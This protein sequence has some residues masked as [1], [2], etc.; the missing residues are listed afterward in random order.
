M[1][2]QE[3]DALDAFDVV[4]DGQQFGEVRAVGHVHPVA[5]DDLAQQGHFPDPLARQGAHLAR[6]L[7]DAPALLRASPERDDAER[8]GVRAAINDRHV[9]ADQVSLLVQGQ[10]QVAVLQSVTGFELLGL[11]GDQ[12]LLKPSLFKKRDHGG[13][14]AWSHEDVDEREAPPQGQGVAHADQAAHQADHLI[15]VLLLQDLE[16]SQPPVNAVFRALAHDAG[17]EHDHVGRIGVVD[18]AQPRSLKLAGEAL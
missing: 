5:V 1:R 2:G 10:S 15:W 4:D 17:V 11:L 16:L 8:A 12:A 18:V 6:D 9:S 13:R 3:A 14:V 7:P